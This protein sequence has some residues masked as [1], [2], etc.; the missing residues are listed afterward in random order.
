MDELLVEFSCN[1]EIEE[2]PFEETDFV[3][4]LG[5]L[6][7][8]AIEAVEKC[9]ASDRQIYLSMQCVNE[10]F[11]LKIKNRSIA[12]PN[13]KNN[14]FITDKEEKNNHGWGIESI[15]RV[16]DKYSGGIKFQYDENFFQTAIIINY[17]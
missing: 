15:K 16:V 6:L 7:D 11:I 9:E 1:I 2:I 12:K 14:R 8:N 3:V 4:I 10:M 5:N 17:K 13:V